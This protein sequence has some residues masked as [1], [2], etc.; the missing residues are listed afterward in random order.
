MRGN[1]YNREYGHEAYN[2][3]PEEDLV[4]PDVTHPLGIWRF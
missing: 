2:Y 1:T 4:S 3:G